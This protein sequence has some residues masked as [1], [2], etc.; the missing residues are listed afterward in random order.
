MSIG[1]RDGDG[2]DTP[3]AEAVIPTLVDEQRARL[4]E[5]AEQLGDLV[6][7]KLGLG[8]FQVLFGVDQIDLMGR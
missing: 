1:F 8:E 4:A 5:I 3:V 6:R 7:G 2:R